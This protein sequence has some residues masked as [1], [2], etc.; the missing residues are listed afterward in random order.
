MSWKDYFY[1]TKRERNGIVV[2]TG[3][4]VIII[5][6]PFM[7][8]H[9][10]P[11]KTYDLSEFDM[12]VEKYYEMLEDYR[13]AKARI[14][15]ANE[16]EKTTAPELILNL[17]TFDPNLASREDFIEM[18]LPERIASNI[19]NYR[20][21]G[22]S[23]RSREDLQRIYSIDEELYTQ[24]E[25]Y[26]G[27]PTREEL[28][29]IRLEKRNAEKNLRDT[30]RRSPSRP[31]WADVMLDI[32]KADSLEWQQIRG[33]GEVFSR[34]IISYRD[35]LGGYYSTIQLMEVYGMDSAR[36]EQIKPHIFLSDTIE[37]RKINI[38]TADFITLIRHPY[39]ER[40]HVN[41]IIRM[42]ERHGPYTS[43]EDILR[44]E[45]INDS[46]YKRISPYLIVTD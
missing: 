16:T 2:L 42:R 9:F 13:L 41:S 20:N 12:K 38:N 34:R 28:N 19:V 23:F 24:L 21:A 43:T 37:L 46:L 36:Y 40:N 39:L 5:I 3:L 25:R 6:T 1:F 33:I 29:K 45:L 27:L 17:Y 8:S 10:I 32:N 7:Y 18:G 15:K 44:S 26:I 11:V 35:L 14:E 4:I 31:A 22:G 30:I